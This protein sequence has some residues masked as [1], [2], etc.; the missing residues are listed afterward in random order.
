MVSKRFVVFAALF[1]VVAPS[2]ECLSQGTSGAQFLGIGMGAR[3]VG[4]GGAYVS[5]ADDG[6]ALYW[7]PAG[8]SQTTGMRLDVSHV[9]WLDDASY[10]YAS[11]ATPLG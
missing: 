6:S 4:M 1:L 7:N 3:S 9:S 2:L 8:L 10:Q 11:F 5:L